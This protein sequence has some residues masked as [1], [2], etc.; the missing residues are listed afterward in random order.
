ME[1]FY[2]NIQGWFGFPKVYKDMVDYFPTNSHFIEVGS[3]LGQSASY[4]GVEILN[5]GKNIRFDCVDTWGG[6][7]EHGPVDKE[8]LF[9]RFLNNIKPVRQVINPVIGESVKIA[10]QYQDLS[11]D[12]VFLDASHEYEDVLA[13]LN[14]WYPKVRYGGVLAGHDY[15]DHS[16]PG[17]KKA[18]DEFYAVDRKLDYEE[19][20]SHSDCFIVKKLL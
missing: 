15:N 6:S 4:M 18:V 5:S 2:Q 19:F 12:F 16:W 11:L 14:A 8:D 9:Y 7:K 10:K 20:S 17:V 13:D 3:W 1:H